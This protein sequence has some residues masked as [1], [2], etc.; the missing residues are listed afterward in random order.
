MLPSSVSKGGAPGWDMLETGRNW[1]TFI[2]FILD[3]ILLLMQLPYRYAT[4]RVA[5]TTYYMLSKS[6][7]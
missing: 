2:S 6:C 5:L 7:A 1:A 4:G 3:S